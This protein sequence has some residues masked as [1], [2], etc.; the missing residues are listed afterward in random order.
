[1]RVVRWLVP[2]MVVLA[3]VLVLA[4]SSQQPAAAAPHKCA[5]FPKAGKGP[6]TIAAWSAWSCYAGDFFPFAWGVSHSLQGMPEECTQTSDMSSPDWSTFDKTIAIDRSNVARLNMENTEFFKGKLLAYIGAE[7]A[8]YE[9]QHPRSAAAKKRR[10]AAIEA[11][12]K[13]DESI[14]KAISKYHSLADTIGTGLQLLGAHN[15][16]V[17]GSLSTDA[18]RLGGEGNGALDT[19]VTLV[20]SID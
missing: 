2:I 19:G 13:A 12:G 5:A 6:V 16:G 10:A 4:A 18:Q 17:S 11:L 8:W 15:C 9:K 3:A 20:G 7:K 14:S 1:M